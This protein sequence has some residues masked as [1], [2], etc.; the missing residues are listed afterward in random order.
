VVCGLSRMTS[1]Q[2]S[3]IEGSSHDGIVTPGEVR[4]GEVR[5]LQ[6]IRARWFL[7]FRCPMT[8][9]A[10]TTGDTSTSRLNSR[11]PAAV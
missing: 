4:A 7:A 3:V 2:G 11:F 8:V 5:R 6:L 10:C 9:A 1:L